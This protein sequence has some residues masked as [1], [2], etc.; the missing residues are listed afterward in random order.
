MIADWVA[1]AVQA[2]G[3]HALETQLLAK[4]TEQFLA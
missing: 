3:R 4:P 1:A 2:E